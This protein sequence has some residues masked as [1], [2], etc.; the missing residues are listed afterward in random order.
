MYVLK[1]LFGDCPHVKIIE[2]LAENAGFDISRPEIHSEIGGSKTTVY[3]HIK[4][5]LKGG[6]VQKTRKVGRTQLIH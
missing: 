4:R 5:L 3:S 6:F 1:D 2:V